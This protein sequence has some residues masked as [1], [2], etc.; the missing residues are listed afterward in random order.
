M[1]SFEGNQS[2]GISSNI[3][4]IGKEIHRESTLKECGE[5]ISGKYKF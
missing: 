3:K 1:I 2:S 5:E 4:G